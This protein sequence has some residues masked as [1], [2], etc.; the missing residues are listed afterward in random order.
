VQGGSGYARDITFQ[1]IV[2]SGV[3]NPIIVDQNYCDDRANNKP[4][5]KAQGSAAVDVSNVVFRNIRGT[6]VTKEAIKLDCSNNVPCHD[7]TLQNID[8]RMEGGGKG[9]AESVCENAKWRKYGTVLPPPC[10][11]KN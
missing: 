6:T 5:S 2:M 10:T 9:V 8:L 1:N 11:S 4:C 7:I 3:Q